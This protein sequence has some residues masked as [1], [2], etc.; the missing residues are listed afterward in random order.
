MLPEDRRRALTIL[1]E[2]ALISATRDERRFLEPDAKVA[3]SE[4]VSASLQA[5]VHATRRDFG[6]SH[7]VEVGIGCESCHGGSREHVLDVKKKPTFEIRSSV[8]AAQPSPRER[9]A[10]SGVHAQG[11]NRTCARCHQVLFSRYPFTWEGGQRNSNAGGSHISS[12]EARDFLLGGCAGSL[13]C[14][15]C[16]DPH[17]EDA[18]AKVAALASPEG[19]R[20]CL[21]CHQKLDTTAALAAHTHHTPSGAGSVC[22]NCHMPKKNL[23]L[24]YNLTRYHRI[25]SPTETSRVEG[26]RPLECALCHVDKTVEQLV[27]SMERFWGKRYDRD[28]LVA[29]YGDLHALPLMAT[30]ARGKAHEQATAIAVL[31]ERRVS[32]A[33]RVVAN[34]ITNPYPLVRYFARQSLERI[35]GRPCDVGLDEDDGQIR[36]Q[37]QAWLA[38]LPN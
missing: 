1:D 12:G 23:G 26:D 13:S 15:A 22:I 8:V 33:T 28:R 30:V 4:K 5:A 2:Q 16:H 17:A 6:A 25:G 32:S 14:V 37:M 36:E 20:V 3:P 38:A 21:G 24:G 7:L 11:I 10:E 29:L 34:E 18:P 35:S 19:N 27:T 31:G 9:Q